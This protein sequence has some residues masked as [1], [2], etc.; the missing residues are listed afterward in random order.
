MI[1]YG[2]CVMYFVANSWLENWLANRMMRVYG[3][4]KRSEQK[5]KY[6]YGF[7]LYCIL[8]V[9]YINPY[10]HKC[11]LRLFFRGAL[12]FWNLIFQTKNGAKNKRK[13][14][15]SKSIVFFLCVQVYVVHPQREPY[16]LLF[17]Q[18]F[19]IFMRL[20]CIVCRRSRF[21]IN[22]FETFGL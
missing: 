17:F 12:P 5:W 9:P 10:I 7:V 6:V 11:Y 4:G 3:G 16:K 13:F 20:N 18:L 19:W 22:H 1:E 21:G 8:C 2:V 14:H 15:I